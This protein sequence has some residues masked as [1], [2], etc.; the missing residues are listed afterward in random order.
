MSLKN[1]RKI[2]EQYLDSSRK[3]GNGSSGKNKSLVRIN[4][5]LRKENLL[6]I[7]IKTYDTIFDKC[8]VSGTE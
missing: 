7:K 4:I 2:G 5:E 3:G 6:T 1:T 8:G